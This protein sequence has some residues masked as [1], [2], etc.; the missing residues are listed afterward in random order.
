MCCKLSKCSTGRLRCA[1]NSVD[2]F[3]T[4]STE[5]LLPRAMLD[6]IYCK[7]PNK[8]TTRANLQPTFL[9]TDLTGST[10]VILFLCT[11][12]LDL[13]FRPISTNTKNTEIDW[14]K[15]N[16]SAA[17]CPPPI[18]KTTLWSKTRVLKIYIQEQS[19]L[20]WRIV[21]LLKPL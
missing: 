10:T 2:T 18:A 19:L 3:T 17:L 1:C 20:Y 5:A 12:A 6:G 4:F 14:S 16:Y 9:A 21:F 13:K 8:T 11:V 7:L 15:T